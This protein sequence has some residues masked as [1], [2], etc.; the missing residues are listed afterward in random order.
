M[1]I[2]TYAEQL[3]EVQAKLKAIRQGAQEYSIGGAVSRSLKHV[4]YAELRK[5][6]TWLRKMVA[7]E[8]RG[9]IL[10]RGATKV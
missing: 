8:S 10:I 5:E 4:D 1:A 2:Q 9:G 6:E 7:R 3:E